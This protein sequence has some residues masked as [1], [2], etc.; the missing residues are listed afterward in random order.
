MRIG[1][2]CAMSFILRTDLPCLCSIDFS[3][4]CDGRGRRTMMMRKAYDVKLFERL[5]ASNLTHNSVLT[6]L[7]S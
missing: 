6:S 7:Y 1:R 4:L 2:V 3:G 5:E